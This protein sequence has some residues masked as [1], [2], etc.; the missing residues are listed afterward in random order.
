MPPPLPLDSIFT[1]YERKS[2]TISYLCPPETIQY[3]PLADTD[4]FSGEGCLDKMVLLFMQDQYLSSSRLRTIGHPV[5][6]TC[7]IWTEITMGELYKNIN[8]FVLH[9]YP[10]L[11]PLIFFP[12][13]FILLQFFIKNLF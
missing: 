10:I 2:L 4:T 5:H 9:C 6:L 12:T 13:S 3:S 7:V 11:T 1:L 8:L